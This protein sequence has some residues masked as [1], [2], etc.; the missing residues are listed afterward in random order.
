MNA[1]AGPPGGGPAASAGDLDEVPSDYCL[2]GG[3]GARIATFVRCK[4]LQGGA[5]PRTGFDPRA[6]GFHFANDFVDKVVTVP[7]SARWPPTVA[8]A[9]WP[10]RPSTTG[11]RACRCPRT[12]P[13]TSPTAP[14]PRTAPAWPTSSTNG[15]STATPPGAPASS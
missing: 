4:R 2:E 5:V 15:C 6:H 13:R 11:S 8:P 3:P 1:L 7:G 9:G 10:S 12:A 14:C